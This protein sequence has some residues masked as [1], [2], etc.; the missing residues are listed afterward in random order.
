VSH[1]NLKLGPHFLL[2]VT[3]YILSQPEA[4]WGLTRVD[5]YTLPVYKYIVVQRVYLCVR[6][7]YLH[8]R[9]LSIQLSLPW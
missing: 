6:A 4:E 2:F 7:N 9:L 5:V 1:Q 8:R 3:K